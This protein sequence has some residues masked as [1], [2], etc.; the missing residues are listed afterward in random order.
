MSKK[1]VFMGTPEFSLKI[2]EIL[3]KEKLEILSVY[4]QPPKKSSRGQKIKFSPIDKLA[5]KLNLEI[6][7]PADLNNKNEYEFFKSLPPCIV[8]V[9]AYGKIIPKKYL[10]LPKKIFIN[11]H[12]SLLPK[13]RGAAPIQRTIMNKEKESGIT[14]MK[15]E[16]ELDSGPYMRQVRVKINEQTNAKILGS[17]LSDLG[18]KN[19]LECI[20]LIDNNKAVFIDQNHK[21]SS[22]AKKIEKKESKINWRDNATDIIAK[23]NAL[24][25]S[26]GAY[27]EHNKIRYKIW[28]ATLSEKVGNYG[29][30]L[31]DK[32][33]VAC[34]D[35]SIQILEIQKEGKNKLTVENFLLGSAIKYGDRILC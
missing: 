2:L 6:R 8:I 17:I 15:I 28:K 22:Y 21:N 11:I 35:K 7:N 12:A 26:P 29:E 5:K 33:T 24:N 34:K 16:E 4:T 20:D 25:P 23:I 32:L 30:I 9:V 3:S 10:D 14:I 19:I 31:D 1:I 18:A 13:W 27:F